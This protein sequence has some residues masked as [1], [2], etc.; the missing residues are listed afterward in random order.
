MY[1]SVCIF[2][3]YL[4]LCKHPQQQPC[5][6]TL[7]QSAYNSRKSIHVA[8]VEGFNYKRI[9]SWINSL[10][11]CERGILSVIWLN[12]VSEPC[13]PPGSLTKTTD[14][15]D[16]K[17]HEL[18]VAVIPHFFLMRNYPDQLSISQH[19]Q[20]CCSLTGVHAHT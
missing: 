6:S 8:L 13:K 9:L 1:P 12:Q 17:K 2:S 19:R 18:S 7:Q 15:Q 20:I 11:R 3:A 14:P 10:R 5:L 4:A 16:K